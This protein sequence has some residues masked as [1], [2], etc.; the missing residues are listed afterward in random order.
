MLLFKS[1]L[2]ADQVTVKGRNITNIDGNNITPYVVKRIDGAN[3]SEV[4]EV[5]QKVERF[6]PVVNDVGYSSKRN[7]VDA[8]TKDG[9]SLFPDLVTCE[10][11]VAMATTME[12]FSLSLG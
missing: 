5:Y 10:N 9:I 4:V 2:G 12:I 1:I 6:M 7:T 11:G 3:R 8:T